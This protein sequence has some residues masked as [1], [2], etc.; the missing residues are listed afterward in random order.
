MAIA[1]PETMP[2]TV[3]RPHSMRACSAPSGRAKNWPTSMNV[4]VQASVMTFA[5]SVILAS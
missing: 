5:V 1:P 3:G 4:W 2:G